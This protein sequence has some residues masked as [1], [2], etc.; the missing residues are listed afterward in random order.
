MLPTPI[1]VARWAK[2]A[3]SVMI[4]TRGTPVTGGSGG[5]KGLTRGLGRMLC[6]SHAH[7]TH[8]LFLAMLVT[9]V[10]SE[11]F[12]RCEA[13]YF[14]GLVRGMTDSTG[15]MAAKQTISVQTVL[16]KLSKHSIEIACLHYDC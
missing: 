7:P 4:T 14:L 15:A 3:A 6:A 16:Y 13:C 1:T 11:Q 12:L 2:R 10:L 9:N 8:L 5:A